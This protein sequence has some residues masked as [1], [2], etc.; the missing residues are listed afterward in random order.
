MSNDLVA[1]LRIEGEAGGAVQA[2]NQAGAA[3]GQLGDE[4]KRSAGAV[5]LTAREV[6]GLEDRVRALRGS[7]DPAY[8][9]L[10]KLDGEMA[11]AA[12]LYRAGAIQGNEYVA[13]MAKLHQRQQLVSASNDATTVSMTRASQAGLGLS[14]QLA[15][16]GTTA[17][18]GMNP[19]MILAQQGPQIA[20]QF[21]LMKMQGVSFGDAMKAMGL[22][23][24]GL[25]GVI[26]T[27]PAS[28]AAMAAAEAEVAAVRA[29][30]AAAIQVEA[31]AT[32]ELAAAEAALVR[33]KASAIQVGVGEAE[34]HVVGAAAKRAEA[35]A[36]VELAA[37]NV[38]VAETAATAAAAET[39]ALAPM[40][41]ILAGIAVA[42]AGVAGAMAL[43]VRS[44]N[45]EHGDLTKT[46][47]LTEKQLDR[48]KD[49][50]T[51]TGVT[52]GDAFRGTFNYLRDATG[53]ALKPIADWFSKLFDDITRKTVATVKTL[54][55]GFIGGYD[56]IKATW[57]MLP[58]AFG[59]VMMQAANG[60]IRGVEWAINKAIDGINSFGT[61]AAAMLLGG[62]IGAILGP[63][64]KNAGASPHLQHVE[65]GQMA[66][67]NAGAANRT[68]DAAIE[69]FNGGLKRGGALVERGLAGLGAAIV[70]AAKDRIKKEAGDPEKGR[71]A[72]TAKDPRDQTDERTAQVDQ[73]LAQAYAEELQAE[74]SIVKDADRRAD[75]QQQVIMAQTA[76]RQA[77]VDR[78][79]ADIQDDKGLSEAKKQELIGKL[80]QVQEINVSI[81]LQ[82]MQNVD[83]QRLAQLSKEALD[84]S[85][86]RHQAQIDLLQSEADLKVSGYARAAVEAKILEE[87]QAIEREKLEQ[88]LLNKNST[89]NDRDIAEAQLAVLDAVQANARTLKQRE[90]GI[91]RAL[92]EA[93]NAV[94]S[95]KDAFSRH[96]FAGA[97]NSLLQTIQTIQAA[98]Q[99]QGMTGG[100][101]T[102]A[103]AVGSLIGGKAGNALMFGA[104]VT[105]AASSLP[106]F[107]ATLLPG[108]ADSGALS[109]M[110]GSI[111]GLAGPIGIIAGVAMLASSFL[112]GKPSNHAGIA[113]ITSGQ[114]RRVS[115]GK[116]TKETLDAAS[117]AGDAILQGEAL[118]E[119]LGIKPTS[120]VNAVDLGTR[121]KT[122]IV[123]SDGSEFRTNSVGDAAEAADT[124][125]KAVLKGANFVDDTQKKLVESMLAA[126]E[127]FDA[128]SKRLQQY[129]AAQELPNTI[130]DEIQKL[131][132][133]KG[134]AVT[135]LERQ[136]KDRRDQIQKAF[137]AGDLTAD[138]FAR[139]NDQLKTL[140]GLE[141]DEVMKQFSDATSD[142]TSGLK[143]WLASLTGVTATPTQST[144]QAYAAL[145]AAG[146]AARDGDKEAE[147]RIPDLGNAY[148]AAARRSSSSQLEFQQAVG[149]ARA[150]GSSVLLADTKRT[151][152][153]TGG[154]GQLTVGGNGGQDSQLVSLALTPREVL[155]VSREDTMAD[156]VAVARR[157]EAGIADLK[158]EHRIGVETQAATLKNIDQREARWD[159]QGMPPSRD[160]A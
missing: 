130:A 25:L 76:S 37:A 9:S 61:Q 24:G 68:A 77:A 113:D 59:D 72:R 54:V 13:M 5:G 99:H 151:G 7:I 116:E 142:A 133:P 94:R 69:A 86:A 105:T 17:A 27:V 126:G 140:E 103:G 98:F 82:Q 42:A 12:S 131:T 89:Q 39:V 48:L 132:D 21:T 56:A 118:L 38:T 36:A 93:T 58:A 150:I 53:P 46:M 121:D 22:Q 34:A 138:A 19:L 135:Q 74:L 28:Q 119:S 23:L 148:I 129:A 75:L 120:K 102:A 114:V 65:L 78:Q 81:A 95:F 104:S 20:D 40:A 160:A 1:R 64:L 154:Q 157:I 11:E 45:K 128:I 60:V 158:A 51:E 73:A 31:A 18:A 15:D 108:L 153:A 16:I 52:I 35:V 122:R 127:G 143:A 8:S 107:A 44:L 32:A 6:E 4:A 147:A 70:N 41:G 139:V 50:G 2:A 43:G 87:Q 62:P 55:G 92:D 14:R 26:R 141:L 109:G 33:I 149:R 123:M 156:L 63:M 100:V 10:R 88:V 146:L 134:Y 144:E 29:A 111:A 117:N 30:A 80:R 155:N 49:K 112:G 91:D 137:D 67:S 79:I 159:R 84:L 83:D 3:V 152:F 97:M 47:G 115:T 85:T 101:A 96:D 110:L 125:L 145:R 124:A 57:N 71:K 136:Q 106:S 66:N 90:L